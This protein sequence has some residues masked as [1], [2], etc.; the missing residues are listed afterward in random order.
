MHLDILAQH[1]NE[2]PRRAKPRNELDNPPQ[3][4]ISKREQLA[5][6]A[7]SRPPFV[8]VGVHG[9]SDPTAYGFTYGSQELHEIQRKA[10]EASPGGWAHAKKSQPSLEPNPFNS[11]GEY[12][13]PRSQSALPE[14]ELTSTLGYMDKEA[15]FESVSESFGKP[16]VNLVGP[17]Y[18]REA[19]RRPQVLMP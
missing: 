5:A 15:R 13:A 7:E 9:G 8:K 17:R 14:R 16:A 4:P 3:Q 2:H 1:I 10:K 11:V 18:G 19:P 12:L 6:A